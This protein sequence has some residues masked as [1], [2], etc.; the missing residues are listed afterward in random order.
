[1]NL[2][3]FLLKIFKFE[4][5]FT[6]S[7]MIYTLSFPIPHPETRKSASQTRRKYVGMKEEIFEMLTPE[8][9]K[10]LIEKWKFLEGKCEELFLGKL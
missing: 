8:F 5:S 9:Q 4:T 2:S 7:I 1:M 3:I 10:P 6:A